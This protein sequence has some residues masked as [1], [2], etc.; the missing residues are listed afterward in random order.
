MEHVMEIIPRV[1]SGITDYALVFTN[2]RVIRAIIY[3]GKKRIATAMAI[4]FVIG[5]LVS[6][7]SMKKQ[8]EKFS[9]INAEEILNSDKRNLSFPYSSIDRIMMKKPGRIGKAKIT[10]VSSGKLYVMSI[11]DK[12][13]V[14]EF[15]HNLKS[16]IP[17]K[18]SLESKNLTVQNTSIIE[19]SSISNTDKKEDTSKND[20]IQPQNQIKQNTGSDNK[21]LEILKERL[22]KGEI[23]KEEYQDLKQVFDNAD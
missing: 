4:G 9:N 1:T 5:E 6:R 21:Y 20:V 3:S 2:E 22:A 10:I 7:R 23:T 13:R 18:I 12:K 15:F 11:K 14:D 16:I 17:N 8:V 19:Q